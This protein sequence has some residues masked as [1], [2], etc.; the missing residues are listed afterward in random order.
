MR[1]ID[2]R[3]FVLVAHGGAGLLHAAESAWDPGM[4]QVIVPPLPGAFSAFGLLVAE[5]RL[6]YARSSLL[7]L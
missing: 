4:P 5:R 7:G 3:Q 1:G 6:D 2:L